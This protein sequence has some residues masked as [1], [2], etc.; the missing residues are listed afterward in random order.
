MSRGAP[1]Q[2]IVPGS[3]PAG[4]RRRLASLIYEALLLA[5]VLLVAGFAILPMVS[6]TT[7][8]S[9]ALPQPLTG[10]VRIAAFAWHLAVAGSY[11]VWM[12]SGGRR[13]LAMRTWRMHLATIHG[14]QVNARRAIARFAGST[15]GPALAIA[16][17][18]V[19]TPVGL[20]RWAWLGLALNFVW[21]WADPERAFLHDR[22]AGTRLV[23]D[24]PALPAGPTGSV[25]IDSARHEPRRNGGA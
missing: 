12:W 7:P 4:L 5:A 23:L 19:L 9:P 3:P 15:L 20:G 6:P 16:L 11:F 2:P 14:N 17:H 22:L 10:R 13:T 8:G 18:Q 1:A 24:E 25:A 21:A